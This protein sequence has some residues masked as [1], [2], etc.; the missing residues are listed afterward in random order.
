[1]VRKKIIGFLLI[2]VLFVS[3]LLVLSGQIVTAH[4]LVVT[5]NYTRSAPTGLDDPVWSAAEAVQLLVEG[6]E[7]SAGSNGTV[8][9]RALYSDDS[10]HFLFK[11]KDPTRSITKSAEI[12]RKPMI[13]FRTMKN[14]IDCAF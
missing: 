6:R 1:M 2:S 13:F 9:A 8:T 5:A 4:T 10:L 3:G 12:R 14:L 11:W 7:R